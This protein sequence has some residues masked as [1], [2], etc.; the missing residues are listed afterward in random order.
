MLRLPEPTLTFR[1]E[2]C[3][4]FLRKH[5]NGLN[6]LPEF[7]ENP[8]VVPEDIARFQFG[9]FKNTFQEIAWIFMRITGQETTTNI[10]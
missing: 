2:Y 7:L 3:R 8:M 10:S 1:G 5:E 9:A 6:L 4:E